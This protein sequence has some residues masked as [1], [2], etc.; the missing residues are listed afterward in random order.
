MDTADR[1]LLSAVR[2]VPAV[3]VCT[4]TAFVQLSPDRNHPATENRVEVL[5][6]TPQH[7]FHRFVLSPYA[8]SS[9]FFSRKLVATVASCYC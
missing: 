6:M 8:F 4:A 3:S 2:T 1:K 7:V 5:H 9:P